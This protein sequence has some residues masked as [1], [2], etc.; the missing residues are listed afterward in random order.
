MLNHKTTD[1]PGFTR[2]VVSSLMADAPWYEYC[3]NSE[4]DFRECVEAIVRN[5]SA[6]NLDIR[7]AGVNAVLHEID[8]AVCVNRKSTVYEWVK[9]Y[10]TLYLHGFI[11][12]GYTKSAPR[13]LQIFGAPKL[14]KNKTIH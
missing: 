7:I 8:P 13:G 6:R 10:W 2:H 1:P 3:P 12:I 9:T 14:G 11:C 4:D 5:Y